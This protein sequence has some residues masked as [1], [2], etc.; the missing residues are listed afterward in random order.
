MFLRSVWDETKFDIDRILLRDAPIHSNSCS[1]QRYPS[2]EKF[3]ET[4]LLVQ[5]FSLSKCENG[6]K[7]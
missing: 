7:L 1:N 3:G 5:K 4:H 6:E 2:R